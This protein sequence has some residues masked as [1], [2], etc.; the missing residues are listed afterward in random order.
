MKV[1][2]SR[3][4]CGLIT[5]ASFANLERRDD[6]R[7]LH[8]SWS[9]HGPR[10]GTRDRFRYGTFETCRPWAMS[11]SRGRPESPATCSRLSRKC[12]GSA[13]RPTSSASV[14]R[15]DPCALLRQLPVHQLR[16]IHVHY[17]KSRHRCASA[18]LCPTVQT[19]LNRCEIIKAEPD[20]ISKRPTTA[21]S[22]HPFFQ[23][24]CAASW[25]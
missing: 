10:S 7:H 13:D 3:S 19:E 2:S 23:Q 5:G 1:A 17:L 21:L 20:R 24:L 25:T 22:A 14:S 9:S 12:H 18:F 16:V 8:R 11:V 15:L 4:G 6:R